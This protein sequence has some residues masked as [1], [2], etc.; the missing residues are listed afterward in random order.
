VLWRS[1]V[2]AARK[3]FALRGLPP[4]VTMRVDEVAGQGVL[5]QQ[6]PLYWVHLANRHGFKPW[7][8]LFIYNLT[9]PAV[10]ELRDLIQRDQATAFPHAFGRA[11]AF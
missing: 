6:S 9:E 4:L 11:P 5:W 10:N 2:W 3:P 1:L 8:G 7:L